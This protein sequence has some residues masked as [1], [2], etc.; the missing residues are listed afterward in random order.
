MFVDDLLI[1]GKSQDNINYIKAF[2]MKRFGRK[3]IGKI[4]TYLVLDIVYDIKNN[5]MSS[6][7]KN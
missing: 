7:Q 6:S 1:C 4:R 5:K 3:C 2:L